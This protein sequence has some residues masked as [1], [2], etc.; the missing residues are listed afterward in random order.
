METQTKKVTLYLSAVLFFCLLIFGSFYSLGAHFATKAEPKPQV[1]GAQNGP[2]IEINQIKERLT[3]YFTPIVALNFDDISADSFLAYDQSTG[4]WLAEKSPDEPQMIASLTKLMTVSLAKQYLNSEKSLVVTQKDIVKTSPNLDLIV[5]DSVTVKDLISSILVGSANDAAQTLGNELEKELGASIEAQMNSEAYKLSMLNSYFD[6]PM[7]FDSKNNYST[8]SDLKRLTDK[9]ISLIGPEITL[10]PEQY[11]FH[12]S[13]GNTYRIRATS[14]LNK[15]DKNSYSIK[16]GRTAGAKET[17]IS[18]FLFKDRN[19][20]I[21]LLGSN[22]R[23]KD[24]LTI[25]SKI[26]NGY[27]L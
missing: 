22:N 26:I 13:S 17:M 10:N 20:I 12:S 9:A 15:K 16:T 3:H 6:N 23:E 11:E 24:A 19:I 2:D 1:L 5:G 18:G 27:G 7:G 14:K 25:K 4:Q 8:A 21:I